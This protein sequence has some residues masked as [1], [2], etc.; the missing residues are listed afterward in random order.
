MEREVAADRAHAGADQHVEIRS[1]GSRV[2]EAISGGLDGEP[3][4]VLLSCTDPSLADPGEALND[5]PEP[6]LCARAQRFRCEA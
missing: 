6:R 4:G 2:V 1:P 3:A 5:G